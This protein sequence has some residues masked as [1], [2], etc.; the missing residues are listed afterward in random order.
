[1][2][3]GADRTR[4]RYLTAEEERQLIARAEAG[5]AQAWESL[6]RHF[7]PPLFGLSLRL[8]RNRDDAEDLAGEAWASAMRSVGSYDPDKARFYTWLRAIAA[9]KAKDLM[10]ERRASTGMEGEARVADDRS[11]EEWRVALLFHLYTEVTLREGGPP[12]QVICGCFNQ[13]LARTRQRPK[14][15][16]RQLAHLPLSESAA[17][18]QEEYLEESK[19][20]GWPYALSAAQ[21][22]SYFAPLHANLT[23]KVRDVLEARDDLGRYPDD[24]LERTAGETRLQEY[25]ASDAST[26][27]SNWTNRVKARVIRW[28]MEHRELWQEG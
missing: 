4:R 16:A 8:V 15:I 19:L 10:G 21:V 9:N 22:Q 12:H 7:W 6:R 27:I 2:G 3:R 5:E 25:C 1:M 23:R 17:K 13:C 14:L 18:L 26:H 28:L 20:K 11:D 24:F